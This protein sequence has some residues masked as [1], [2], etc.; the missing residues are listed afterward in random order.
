M[1]T[2]LIIMIGVAL[3]AI[4]ITSVTFYNTIITKR[5]R[6]KVPNEGECWKLGFIYYNPTD[7]RVFLPK[8]SGL[9]YTL[10]FAKP[11]SIILILP[12]LIVIAFSII[13]II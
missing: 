4:A 2:Q 1:N 3:L 12:V 11:I 7:S 8:R 5:W 13:S 9:G 10:N 6:N